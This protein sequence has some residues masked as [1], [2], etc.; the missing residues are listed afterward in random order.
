ML[1]I[2][3]ARRMTRYKRPLLFDDIERLT[4]LSG[5]HPVQLVMAGKAHPRDTG[6]KEA[7]RRVHELARELRGKLTCVFLPGYDMRL[8]LSLLSGCDV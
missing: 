5:R 6:G 8:A 2:G 3:F 1:T 7:I 4:A